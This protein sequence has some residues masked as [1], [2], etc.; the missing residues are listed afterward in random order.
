MRF[1]EQEAGWQS[2]GSVGPTSPDLGLIFLRANVMIYRE[3]TCSPASAL[4]AVQE[5]ES[6]ASLPSAEGGCTHELR[7]G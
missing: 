4:R 5:D 3:E 7:V 6:I 1:R 2:P